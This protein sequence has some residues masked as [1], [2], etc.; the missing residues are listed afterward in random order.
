MSE[1]MA[2]MYPRGNMGTDRHL[3]KEVSIK[4]VDGRELLQYSGMNKQLT[5]EDVE[6]FE[7]HIEEAIE[8]YRQRVKHVTNKPF[9]E[10]IT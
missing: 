4:E 8:A 7:A 10:I 2:I 3:K 9:M 1:K 6:F 5:P